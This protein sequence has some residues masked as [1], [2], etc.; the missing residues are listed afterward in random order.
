M[1]SLMIMAGG[2]SSRMK[3]SL[4]NSLLSSDQKNLAQRV[5]KSLIPLGTNQKPLLF[6]LISNAVAVGYTD[7]FLITSPDNEA[8]QEWVGSART[9]NSFAGAKVHFAI[10]HLKEGREKPL[11]TAD[12]VEQAMQQYP[13][14]LDET[15]TICNGDNLYS[16]GAFKQLL[17]NRKT[18]NALISY[19]RSSL[20]FSD[21]RIGKFAVMDIDS[22]GFLN[23]IIEKPDAQTAEK[24]QDS[25]GEIRV[26]MNIFSFHGGQLNPY[27]KNCPIH[28]ERQEKELPTAIKML[29]EN[30][31]K[32]IICFGREEHI[33]DLTSAQDIAAFDEM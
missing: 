17:Q 9:G 8:F 32:Q 2:A 4:E 30:E 25:K 20:K 13:A 10:Q 7:V 5:H 15:F 14:L 16:E 24:Y 23:G 33:L 18:P 21:E 31:P 27:L 11:G 26:S 1:K 28:P 19:A 29:N 12:A 22:E 6:H 3:K